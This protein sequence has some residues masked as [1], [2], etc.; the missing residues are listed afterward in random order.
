MACEELV[1]GGSS[2]LYS[3]N[4]ITYVREL[5]DLDSKDELG[6]REIPEILEIT[7]E[8][9]WFRYPDLR[10][11]NGKKLLWHVLSLGKK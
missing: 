2:L 10:L 5:L 8:G 6:D 1:F 3:L 4:E 7:F 11:A 9:V